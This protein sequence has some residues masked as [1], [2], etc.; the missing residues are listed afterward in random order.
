M[1]SS[2]FQHSSMHASFIAP[3]LDSHE[4]HD[5][6]FDQLLAIGTRITETID[7]DEQDSYFPEVSA[8]NLH[9]KESSRKILEVSALTPFPEE[10]RHVY[11]H[12]THRGLL[13][14]INCVWAYSARCLA[15]WNYESNVVTMYH[16]IELPVITLAVARSRCL[17]D[18]LESVDYLLVVATEIEIN[19]LGIHF[20][21]GDPCRGGMHIFS[22]PYYLPLSA[23]IHSITVSKDGHIYLQGIDCEISELVYIP[24]QEGQLPACRQIFFDSFR[25]LKPALSFA[26]R[27][28]SIPVEQDPPLAFVVDNSRDLLYSL[29]KHGKLQ[30]YSIDTSKSHSTLTYLSA[31]DLGLHIKYKLKK[32]NVVIV[33]LHPLRDLDNGL[34]VGEF[35]VVCSDASRVFY[36]IMPGVPFDQAKQEIIVSHIHLE[37][38]TCSA[39]LCSKNV[40]V[41]A[42][43]DRLEPSHTVLHANIAE[44]N[45][46]MSSVSDTT[47]SAFELKTTYV[48]P[49]VVQQISFKEWHHQI[50]KYDPPLLDEW[51]TTDRYL[52]HNPAAK[53]GTPGVV[54]VVLTPAGIFHLRQRSP[55]EEIWG[56]LIQKNSYDSESLEEFVNYY[57][58]QQTLS[59]LLSGFQVSKD[60][61]PYSATGLYPN[62]GDHLAHQFQ[63]RI[64]QFKFEALE[65]KYNTDQHSLEDAML[66]MVARMLRLYWNTQV[67]KMKEQS[68]SQLQISRSMNSSLTRDLQYLLGLVKQT[69][70]ENDFYVFI[71]RALELFSLLELMRELFTHLEPELSQA[72]VSL[73]LADLLVDR[74]GEAFI[75]SC[76]REL[77]SNRMLSTKLLDTLR[78]SSPS[79][80]S[81]LMYNAFHAEILLQGERYL[82]AYQL[83]KA[84]CSL[85]EFEISKYC[86]F[87][88]DRHCFQ[89]S[90]SL[91]FERGYELS[92]GQASLATIETAFQ[93]AVLSLEALFITSSKSEMNSDEADNQFEQISGAITHKQSMEDVFVGVLTDWALT[94][95]KRVVDKLL[96]CDRMGK[97]IMKRVL[98][99]LRKENVPY[100]QCVSCARFAQVYYQ[101]D[102]PVK[103]TQVLLDVSRKP[104]LDG[105]LFVHL[106]NREFI[107]HPLS[108]GS[109]SFVS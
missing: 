83:L 70:I 69:I 3:P 77:F 99:L 65:E 54:L 40:Y 58:V 26:T 11:Y 6:H 22:T 50:R 45:F 74:S 100:D 66:L 96:T 67:F 73:T 98:Q 49:E 7:R 97:A 103:A 17:F 94:S 34:E 104:A 12:A 107:Q 57:G 108:L 46:S 32:Q 79:Y 68:H 86:H 101:Q 72:A 38:N 102:N 85:P 89:F 82:D 51:Y 14:T 53:Y 87:F 16:G 15:L 59:F 20:E 29:S 52:E 81:L 95:Q 60:S 19:I 33:G 30:V 8:F 44:R 25:F 84:V 18:S 21:H 13:D 64:F 105:M 28:L 5:S 43:Q 23:P 24:L 37:Q 36:K 91:A 92:R 90:F 35:V 88:R 42:T 106:F 1:D 10:F 2:R 48:I 31:A 71:R 75:Q 93:E 62:I 78:V 9:A 47:Y 76:M 63:Q 41:Y 61:L 39:G 27:F 80:C 109:C 4:A 56:F 55:P